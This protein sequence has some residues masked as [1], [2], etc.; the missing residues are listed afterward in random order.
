MRKIY[1][2]CNEA[3]GEMFY[4]HDEKG[5]YYIE[6]LEPEILDELFSDSF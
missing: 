4:N 3:D 1:V 2:N 6:D 5:Y